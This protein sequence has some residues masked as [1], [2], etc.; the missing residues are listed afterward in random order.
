LLGE[1]E[2]RSANDQ[3]LSAKKF[4]DGLTA[5][6]RALNTHGYNPQLRISYDTATPFR[7]LAWGQAYSVIRFDRDSMTLGTESCPDGRAL[8]GS[9]VRFPW[10]SPLGDRMTLGDLNARPGENL[11]S[12]RDNTGNHLLAHHNLAALC[13]AVATANRILF[14]EAVM[15]QHTIATPMGEAIVAIDE[16]LAA[17]TMDAVNKRRRIFDAVTPVN[18]DQ[19]PDVDRAP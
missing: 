14:S 11:S 17:G 12:Y 2:H 8:V 19:D 5:I 15:R 10:P 18:E 3:P 6:Q 1:L 16:A 13:Y 9:R 7:M 4:K